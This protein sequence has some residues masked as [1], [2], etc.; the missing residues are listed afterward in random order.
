MKQLSSIQ[1]DVIQSKEEEEF[2]ENN[3]NRANLTFGELNGISEAKSM[4]SFGDIEHYRSF[5]RDEYLSGNVLTPQRSHGSMTNGTFGT[6]SFYLPSRDFDNTEIE[7]EDTTLLDDLAITFQEALDDDGQSVE[8]RLQFPKHFD[9]ELVSD[10]AKN[11]LAGYA[12][13]TLAEMPDLMPKL[14]RAI[15]QST[16]KSVKVLMKPKITYN[17]HQASMKKRPEFKCK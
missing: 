13:D 10:Y 1:E 7:I 15:K 9:A 8:L 16:I 6:S 5:M 2:D 3:Q 11:T 12:T 17:V 14:F 4:I